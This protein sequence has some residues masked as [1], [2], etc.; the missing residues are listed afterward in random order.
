MRQMESRVRAEH[1]GQKFST[2]PTQISCKTHSHVYIQN[3]IRFQGNDST[4]FSIPEIFPNPSGTDV[5]LEI[6]LILFFFPKKTFDNISILIM[7]LIN[8]CY[9]PPN[10]SPCVKN[11]KNCGTENDTVWKI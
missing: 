5:T 7:M 1:S 11:I 6:T 8:C 4:C 2:F 3:F 10:W 9:T